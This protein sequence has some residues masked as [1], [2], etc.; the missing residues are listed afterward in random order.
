M[1]FEEIMENWNKVKIWFKTNFENFKMK[2]EK[3]SLFLKA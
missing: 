1:S 3:L 2:T